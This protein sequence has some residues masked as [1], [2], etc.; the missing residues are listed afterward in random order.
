MNNKYGTTEIYDKK[1]GSLEG[2]N[3]E[4]KKRENELWPDGNKER[5]LHYTE[6][7]A[8]DGLDLLYE[9]RGRWKKISKEDSRLKEEE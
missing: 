7:Y 9:I 2:L 1:W 3:E 5:H 4:I 8:K 6:Q